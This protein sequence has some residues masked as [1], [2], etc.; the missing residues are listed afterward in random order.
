MSVIFEV[1]RSRHCYIENNSWVKYIKLLFF[2]SHLSNPNQDVVEL[3]LERIG[4]S[5]SLYIHERDE[6]P[7]EHTSFEL[8]LLL[9]HT[10]SLKKVSVKENF[11]VLTHLRRDYVLSHNIQVIDK[12]SP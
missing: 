3:V 8:S 6:D 4:T 12:P 9:D 5:I 7:F 11:N 1:C 10:F 2:H